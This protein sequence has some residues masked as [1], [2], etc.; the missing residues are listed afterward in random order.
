M[1]SYKSRVR[2]SECDGDGRLTLV[3]MIDYLQDCSTF[4]SEELGLGFRELKQK[5][6]GWILAAW[7]I[8][9]DRLPE[10]GEEIDV[11]TWCYEMK[12]LHAMRN[13][14]I[15][16]AKG[17]SCVRA[18][19]QWL[20][21]SL[22]DNKVVRIPSELEAYVEDTPRIPMPKMQ[23]KLRAEGPGTQASPITVG[24]QFLDSNG[25]VNNAQYVLMAIGALEELG[26]E[27]PMSTVSV[28]YRSMARLGDAVVP[29]V[30]D[31][32]DGRTIE[33]LNNMGEAYAIVKLQER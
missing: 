18:E 4:H 32:E 15:L 33:L 11:H 14:E 12:S 25:H 8:E 23:R 5:G 20:L 9:I 21:Y 22:K 3:S 19:S 17:T 31:A 27:A 2:Y 1:Y 10:F 16:D 29:V 30:H 7:R 13:F 6:Y 28:Q 26:V 24:K